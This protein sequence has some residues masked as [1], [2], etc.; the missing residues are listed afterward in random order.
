[1]NIILMFYTFG[2]IKQIEKT[3]LIQ[4]HK[5]ALVLNKFKVIDRLQ[6]IY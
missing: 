3:A 4:N 2:E 1:M 5:Q 6:I